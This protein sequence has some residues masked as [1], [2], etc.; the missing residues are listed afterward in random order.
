MNENKDKDL[1]VKEEHH[2]EDFTSLDEHLTK[3]CEISF[4]LDVV[5][6]RAEKVIYLL[7]GGLLH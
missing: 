3:W 2:K 1:P 5:A 7:N 6:A 4:E